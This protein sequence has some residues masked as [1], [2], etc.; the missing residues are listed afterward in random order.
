[1]QGGIQDFR[2]TLSVQVVAANPGS[3]HPWWVVVARKTPNDGSKRLGLSF[4]KKAARPVVL[5]QSTLEPCTGASKS[6]SNIFTC[7]RRAV[8][9][10]IKG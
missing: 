8:F 1:L 10:V 4:F 7:T 3:Y 2:K 5:S 6:N 9:E